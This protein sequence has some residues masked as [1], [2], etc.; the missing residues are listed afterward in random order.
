M[1]FNQFFFRAFAFSP[2]DFDDKTDFDVDVDVGK[3][4]D[5]MRVTDEAKLDDDEDDDKTAA[6]QSTQPRASKATE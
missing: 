1:R 4:F 6:S 5:A 2:F 3:T